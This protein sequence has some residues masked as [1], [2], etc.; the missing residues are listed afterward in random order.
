MA[1]D[2]KA[3]HQSFLRPVAAAALREG[4]PEL[5]QPYITWYGQP[6]Q[7]LWRSTSGV[8]HVHASCGAGQGCSI[9]S[10]AYC[11]SV[12]KPL[13]EAF[14]RILENDNGARVFL[15]SD[16]IQL[17]TLP[18]HMQA[19]TTVIA[20][21]LLKCGLTIKE[22]KTK[23]WSKNPQLELPEALKKYRVSELRCLGS[24]LISDTASD[25]V[26]SVLGPPPGST[27]N[28]AGHKV[29]T[30]AR[31]CKDLQE[32]GL[33]TH[34]ARALLRFVAN[35]ASQHIIS[36]QPTSSG[37]LQAYDQELRKAWE[38]V[39]DLKFSDNAW[40]RAQLPLREGGLATGATAQLLPRAA[41]AFAS[42]WSRTGSYV[43]S[44][45]GHHSVDELLLE[46]I[47]LAN[48]LQAAAVALKE[49]GMHHSAPWDSLRVPSPTS[50]GKILRKLA[51][52]M[53]KA[54]LDAMPDIAAA[55]WRSSSGPGASG[56]LLPPSSPD[57]LIDNVPFRIAVARRFGGGLVAGDNHPPT[58]PQ[59]AHLSRQG[60]CNAELDIHGHH[61]SVCSCGGYIIRRHDRLVKWLAGWLQD[62]RAS[63][64]VHLEQRLTQ[65]DG[66]SATV[67]RRI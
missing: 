27:L 30:F 21:A 52:K 42:T 35:G 59:C 37:H 39:M 17:W 10:L 48:Q 28:E 36:A 2:V 12:A 49:A 4:C 61:A 60:P 31:R 38:G 24:K 11:S 67:T 22:S 8:H 44:Q 7:H 51:S 43:A 3:A 57:M 53:R 16:D 63:S 65:Q 62:G 50:Q 56:F 54:Q 25:P 1:L 33:S 55:Q 18:A 5:E 47:E 13:R 64:E 41:A 15:F 45:C 14:Q 29:T 20:A 26:L 40:A 19:A 32:V 46:D 23:I 34:T 66:R 6:Q 58:A 9:A